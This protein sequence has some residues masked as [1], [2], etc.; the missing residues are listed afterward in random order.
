MNQD[1]DRQRPGFVRLWWIASRPYSLTA[2]TMPVIFGTVMAWTIGGAEIHGL[3]F[4]AAFLGMVLLHVGANLLN[5][6]VDFNRGFDRRVNP[7]SGAV[8]RGWITPGKAFA[9]AAALFALGTVF[10]G[11]LVAVVGLPI[12]WIG[13]AG[14]AI[15]ILY[16]AGPFALKYH[17][18][19]DLAVFL[20]FGILGALGAWTTQTGTLSWVPAAWAVP[21]S[22][23]VS[24][25]L[26]ANNW[27]DIEPD[28][29]G[30]ARTVAS[31]LGDRLSVVYYAFLVFSPFLVLLALMALGR[32][33]IGPKMPLTFFVTFL[34]LPLA[35]R[36]MRRGLA[37]KT[38]PDPAL[39]RSLDGATGQLNLAFGLLCTA[40]LVLAALPC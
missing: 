8:V 23:V 33:G 40:A 22:L 5:D 18:V 36:L 6:G 10:L 30:G 14:I 34:A 7:V 37:R 11:M 27:R 4:V 21:M 16:S 2:S 3:R 25:I 15:G 12:L 28:T 39:F 35:V 9:V 29:A 32:L 17:A 19:G 13:L 38:S 1:S 20:D 26:H 31:L 24:G